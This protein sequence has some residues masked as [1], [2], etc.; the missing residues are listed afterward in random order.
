MQQITFSV[1]TDKVADSIEW[2]YDGT[3]VQTDINTDTSSYTHTF[4]DAD[5]GQHTV[6]VIATNG[7]AQTSNT[8]KIYVQTAT[9]SPTTS[10][11]DLILQSGSAQQTFSVT[12][13][14]SGDVTWK[15]DGTSVQTDFGV[16]SSSYTLS[17]TQADIGQHTVEVI[18]SNWGGQQITNS[19]TVNVNGITY[20]PLSN[21]IDI[22]VED[23]SQIQQNFSADAGTT[24]DFTWKYDGTV[25]KTET[26]VTSSSY[27]RIFTSSDYGTHTVDVTV[28]VGADQ[29]SNTWTVNVLS[30]SYSPSSSYLQLKVQEGVYLS[31]TFSVTVNPASNVTWEYDGSVIKQDTSV[32]SS[33]V[34]LT[35]GST[36]VGSHTL[37]VT[38]NSGTHSTAKTWTIQIMEEG[39]SSTGAIIPPLSDDPSL[40]FR[41]SF[42]RMLTEKY[43][44]ESSA[45][46]TFSANNGN[47]TT[48]VSVGTTTE[49]ATDGIWGLKLKVASTSNFGYGKAAATKTLQNISTEKITF[50]YYY[51]PSD[52]SIFKVSV[53]GP[54]GVVIK[55]ETIRGG[56]DKHEI[57]VGAVISKIEFSL[58]LV[59]DSTNDWSIA[60]VDNVVIHRSDTV[61]D[62]TNNTND[63]TNY[64]GRWVTGR[65]G[66]AMSFDGNS[67]VSVPDSNSLDG[68]NPISV[69]ALIKPADI[70]SG[71]ILIK[72]QEYAMYLS[73]GKLIAKI[74]GSGT[75]VVITSNSNIETGNWYFVGF[76]YDGQ[77]IRLYINGELDSQKTQSVTTSATTNNLLIGS[78]G[79]NKYKGLID[80]LK[81][82][83]KV[84]IASEVKS[85][86]EILRVSLKDE[87]TGELINSDG[88]NVSILNYNIEIKLPFDRITKNAV[89]FYANMNTSQYGEFYLFAS[90]QNYY[91]RKL[92]VN[93]QDGT[94]LETSMYFPSTS[95]NVIH[96]TFTFKDPIGK[97]PPQD[98]ILSIKKPFESGSKPVF[99]SYFDSSGKTNT[100]LILDNNYI[101]DL[102]TPSETVSKGWITPDPSGTVLVELNTI[103]LSPSYTAVQKDVKYNFVYSNS[104]IRLIYT[105]NSSSTTDVTFNVY[106][107]SGNLLF[108]STVQGS[109]AQ[110]EF[111]TTGLNDTY[112][113]A[114]FVANSNTYGQIK[115][116]KYIILS[117]NFLDAGIVSIISSSIKNLLFGGFIIVLAYTFGYRDSYKGAVII[118][119]LAA[120]LFYAQLIDIPWVAVSLAL[121]YSI[122][123]Y[124]AKSAKEWEGW[125]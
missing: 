106:N 33:S 19:W 11:V 62:D 8:W 112:V 116:S 51:L 34:T 107:R 42:D 82:F 93:I 40:A 97:Y 52:V 80:E 124:L 48:S 73:S 53:Y 87:S 60:Y 16:T 121:S 18:I 25:V 12:I 66:Y 68:A 99:Q 120:I 24:A 105:D 54:D 59:A 49:W 1:T 115:A 29:Y 98:V 78:D 74:F 110:F 15:Y 17:V 94:Y 65:Y 57:T 2:K 63:G 3:V 35:F 114:E 70:N 23:G 67:Y 26:G 101:V 125:S 45:S 104:L 109:V 4:Y 37:K 31:Q 22:V 36:D 6:E 61:L 21:T 79:T 96:Q 91:P 41:Y 71:Y 95:A 108:T 7:T 122:L 58:E 10:V 13:S 100:Y 88:G 119:I 44:F 32:T 86:D 81:I 89:L 92:I 5:G 38:T 39:V 47:G 76:T 55:T 14:I 83:K 46:W 27:S 90:P 64:G 20:A 75:N 28:T 9:F 69:F 77:T 117:N 50:D 123:A 43:S 85:M 102:I 113:K 103:K 111:N 84:L 56:T 30:I 72:N 118:S